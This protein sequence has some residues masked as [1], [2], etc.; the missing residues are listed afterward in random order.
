MYQVYIPTILLTT[1]IPTFSTI[2]TE[3]ATRLNDYENWETTDGYETAMTQKVFILN[4]I[5]SYLPIFL[6]AFVY[7]PFGSLLVPYL[8]IFQLTAR[9]F[10]ENEKQL[11]TPKA[12]FTINPSRLRKQVIYFTVTAQIVNF[13][14]ETIVPYVKRQGF[15]KY[16]EM[17][18]ASASKKDGSALPAA[19][20]DPPEEAEFLARVRNEAELDVYDVTADLRE[21]IVQFGY[22]ALFSVVWPLTA[23]SFLVNNW[24]ELRSDAVKICVEMQRPT[25][26]RA[27]S[28]GPWLDSLGFLTWL[29]S[30]STAALV[31]L[32]SNDGLGPDGT[33]T[34]IKGW[35][36]LLTIFFSEHIY[37]LVRWAV[38]VAISKMDSP[39]LQKERVERFQI[40]KRY[41]E[42]IMGDDALEA[43]PPL[44]SEKITRASL[45]EDARQSTLRTSGPSDIFWNKQRSWEESARV[46]ASLIEKMAP[47]ES[48]K[49]Q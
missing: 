44:H 40:R 35:A 14:M 4:F 30:I 17:K 8:D 16:Q 10:A 37:L 12:G 34:D 19:A 27:D 23:C 6:T 45:E 48:K 28:I 47:A 9:P 5:I 1:L 29:G 7:V 46:G 13:A 36:L 18:T 26:Y 25:P 11:A 38:R 42:E 33:P 39:G 31:Y 3:V 41:L 2:L 22:L 21:M 15:H 24:I 20:S 32:F 49:K 43:P